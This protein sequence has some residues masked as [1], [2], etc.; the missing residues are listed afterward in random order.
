M[1]PKALAAVGAI[2]GG[3]VWLA[4]SGMGAGRPATAPAQYAACQAEVRALQAALAQGE[5]PEL[6][7]AALIDRA[8]RWALV[9]GDPAAQA[10]LDQAWA[11]YRQ[12]LQP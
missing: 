6:R 12:A 2:L 5:H 7:A 10:C 1:N 3:L 8:A 4:G 9:T 11:L